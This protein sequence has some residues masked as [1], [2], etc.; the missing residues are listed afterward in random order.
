MIMGSAFLEDGKFDAAQREF[1]VAAALN[2]HSLSPFYFSTL[3]A[4]S[5]G[6]TQEALDQYEQIL[7][8]HPNLLDVAEQYK[9]LLIKTGHYEEAIA[10]FE[11]QAGSYPEH[12]HIF[13]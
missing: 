12:G 5:A 13:Y 8:E 3:T 6:R 11:A 7:M 2:P 1:T 9:N 4:E 10:F